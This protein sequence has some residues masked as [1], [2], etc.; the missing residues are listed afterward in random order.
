MTRIVIAAAEET[1]QVGVLPGYSVIGLHAEAAANALAQCGL[2]MSEI[3]GFAAVSEPLGP[4]PVAIAHHLGLVPRWIDA[5]SVGGTSFLSHVRHAMAAIRAGYCHTVLI[6]H[7]ELGRST[8]RRLT[9]LA[10]RDSSEAQFEWPYGASNAITRLGL[11]VRRYMYETG[12]TAEQL[13][14][15]PVSQ[16]MWALDNPR[17]FANSPLTIDDVLAS[18]VVFDPL[19]VRECCLVTDGGGAL[20]VTTEERARD[21]ALTYSPV[22]VVGSGEASDAPSISGMADVTRS[23]A[24]SASIA[25]ALSEAGVTHKDLDHLMIYDAFAH[26]P[27]YGLEALGI[28]GRGEAGDFV[29]EGN[30]RPGGLL[31][32][33]TNGGG[34]S[35]THTGMYGMFAIIE[36]VRQ[37]MGVAYR[38]VEGARLSLVVGNGGMFSASSALVLGKE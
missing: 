17:A 29:A 24:F 26:M 34:L 31:P 10:E 38:Q 32:M 11:T 5:T 9:T 30:T 33:N 21:F 7:G 15:V 25:Q 3:D 18:R 20:V 4:G 16:R 1:D 14:S 13:A 36:A 12:L 27:L 8:K 35:Y 6:T 28:V 37:L 22:H 19:H 2:K 23:L